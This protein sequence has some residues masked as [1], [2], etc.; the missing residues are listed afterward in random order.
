MCF[1]QRYTTHNNVMLRFETQ[2]LQGP[3][4]CTVAAP[5]KVTVSL[6][7]T[8]VEIHASKPSIK[9]KIINFLP[10]FIDTC[11]L[12]FLIRDILVRIR[13]RNFQDPWISTLDIQI[14]IRIRDLLSSSVTS[15]MPTNKKVFFLFVLLRYSTF[16]SNFKDKKSLRSY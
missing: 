15:K 1:V 6:V 5:T 2:A 10:T 11:K 9:A 3:L 8:E 12:V 13:I 16:T 14:Q 4:L 7:F